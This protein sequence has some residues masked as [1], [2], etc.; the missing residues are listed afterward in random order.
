MK[1][2]F[3]NIQNLAPIGEILFSSPD[4][5]NEPTDSFFNRLLFLAQIF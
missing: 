3:V 5:V 4:L 2:S 1:F